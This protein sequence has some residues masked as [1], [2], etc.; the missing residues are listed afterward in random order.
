MQELINQ[1][2]QKKVCRCGRPKEESDLE[3]LFCEEHRQEWAEEARQLK[4]EFTSRGNIYDYEF[5]FFTFIFIFLK[6]ITG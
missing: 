6:M 3:C 4:A 2:N 1:M 5:I